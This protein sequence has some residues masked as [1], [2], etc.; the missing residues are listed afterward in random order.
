MTE[1]TVPQVNFASLGDLPQVYRDA[2]T[3]ANRQQTLASLSQGAWDYDSAAK[4]LVQAGDLQGA[5]S[6]ATIGKS[7][8]EGNGVFGTPIY[9]T[10]P[11]GSTAIGTFDRKGKFRP[12]D[13]GNFTPSPGVKTIETPQGTY[14][15]SGKSGA[16]VGGVSSPQ[17]AQPQPQGQVA[18]PQLPGFYPSDNRG[19]ARDTKL[20]TEEGE[21]M[22]ESGK[23]KAS[24]DTSLNSLDRM[25]FE[26]DRIA[27]D[28]NLGRITGMWGVLP[29]MPGGGAAN[30]NAKLET[31]KSQ[32]AF[33]V[34]QAMR[35]ASKT[36][37]ALG[38]VSDRENTMLTS[39]LAALDRAQSEP[40]FR[41]A[42]KQIV[43]YTKG[44][45]QRLQQAYD[46]DYAS[47]SRPERPQAPVTPQ[48]AQ[49]RAPVR[50]RTPDEARRL[51]SGTQIVLPDGSPGVVP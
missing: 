10:Q 28:K 1:L 39:A 23:A 9:G 17:A 3:Q 18:A 30:V 48:P 38:A 16:T 19:K 37:G 6:L 25:A 20:G 26:A 12:I 36:G 27:N 15:V 35:E 49:S 11:D 4:A 7:L 41:S 14:V 2:R 13:T 22:A 5:M 44:A 34:L 45:K 42:M 32:V 47:L 21:R 24:L 29:N 33:G 46:T 51:P 43:D 8:N 40:E 31:L 50:V